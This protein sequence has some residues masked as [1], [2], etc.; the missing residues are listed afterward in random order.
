MKI[1]QKGN[2]YYLRLSHDGKQKDIALGKSERNAN[3]RGQRFHRTLDQFGFEK[4]MAELKGKDLVKPTKN[5]NFDAIKSLYLD[6][7]KTLS[8]PPRPVTIKRNLSCLQLLMKR[9]DTTAI[10]RLSSEKIK[11]CLP[12]N[13]TAAQRTTYASTVRSAKSIFGKWQMKHYEREGWDFSSP[14]EDVKTEQPKVENYTPLPSKVREKIDSECEE[15]LDPACAMV[16]LMG[17]LLGFRRSEMEACRTSW[18]SI[19]DDAVHVSVKEEK[20]FK[21]KSGEKRDFRTTLEIYT[22]LM[23][24]RKKALNALSD[25]PETQRK[26]DEAGYFI[27]VL[28][29][30]KS[31]LRLWRKFKTVTEWLHSKGSFEPR[32]I[33]Q[34]RKE[35][36]CAIV[37][38]DGLYCT[39]TIILTP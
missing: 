2:A 1:R 4:A 30:K 13:P 34:L 37:K 3:T 21:P 8:S 10:T 24:L 22:R 23:D 16:V 38:S 19:Q 11:S 12:E 14:F 35:A 33:H 28:R 6:Y 9:T 7:C 17:L 31:G 29:R 5:P 27:P 36:G 26:E 39:T 18:F 20:D 15:E 25:N 32:P